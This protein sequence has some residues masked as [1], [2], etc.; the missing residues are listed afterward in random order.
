MSGRRT[1][2]AFRAFVSKV[3]HSA[4]SL[5]PLAVHYSQQTRSL[6]NDAVCRRRPGLLEGLRD[7]SIT[8]HGWA[9]RRAC[10]DVT[11]TPNVINTPRVGD[12]TQALTSGADSREP[13]DVERR[14]MQAGPAP[15]Q[16]G[17]ALDTPH[18]GLPCSRRLL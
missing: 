12:S 8:K 18:G 13:R 1:S 17:N 10:H 9:G 11:N 6:P 5:R 14:A 7:T 3:M 16:I 15:R 4:P 2:L